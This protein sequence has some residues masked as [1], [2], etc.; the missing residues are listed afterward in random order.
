MK[1]RKKIRKKVKVEQ[2][3][4]KEKGGRDRFLKKKRMNK[5]NLGT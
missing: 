4:N 2:V 5:K 3:G 1:D